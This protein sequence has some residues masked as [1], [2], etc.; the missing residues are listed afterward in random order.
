M[1]IYVITN[2]VTGKIYIGQ[3]KGANLMQYLQKKFWHSRNQKTGSSYLFNAMRKYPEYKDWSIE[4]LM[5]FNTKPELD[6]WETR[7]IA[8]FNTR[9]PEVGYNICKGGEG[10]T[11]KHTEEWKRNHSAMMKGRTF[12]PESI[13]KMKA[14]PKSQT[15]L[16]SLKRAST[17]PAVI[18]KRTQRYATDP[19]Y[20]IKISDTSKQRWV[21]PVYRAKMSKHLDAAREARW[22]KFKAEDTLTA[23]IVALRQQG[24]TQR[25]IAQRLG[26]G[27][28][29]VN[30]R[31]KS[32]NL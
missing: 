14:A 3:H 29:V 19:T 21:E 24:M 2:S 18:A 6:L 25:A 30:Y 28:S 4:P 32:V 26:V 1:F 8:L 22:D 15:Q 23:Q 12:S 27:K 13:A 7:L 5:E 9:N 31:L 11:G 10:F 17:D 16:D 20:R